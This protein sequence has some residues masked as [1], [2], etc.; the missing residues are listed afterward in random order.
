[1][2]EQ[3][4]TIYD[5]ARVLDVT[6]S[7]VSRA[8]RNHPRISARTKA[9]VQA[10]AEQLNY[11]QNHI[12]AALRSG[13]TFTLG[14]VVP[15]TNRN[16]FSSVIN[17]IEQLAFNSGYSV[18]ITQSNDS[19]E[20]EQ[21]NIEAL[22][23]AQVDGIIISVAREAGDPAVYQR[24]VAQGVPLVFFD[25]VVEVA[26]AS[27]VLIDDYQGAY[28]ATKHLI[29]QG[30]QRIAHL[31]GASHLN[32]YK[33]RLRG[34]RDALEDHQLPY[35]A[36]LIHTSKQKVADG[37]EGMR[38]LLTLSQPPDAVFAASDYA[39]IGAMQVCKERGLSIPQDVALVGFANEPLTAYLD[40]GLSSVDQMSEQMGRF[41]AKT[42]LEAIENTTDFTPH[43]T[44]LTPDLIVRASSQR[45]R[46]T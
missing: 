19:A 26:G 25:R 11:Q 42:F 34:Y 31:T 28:Q 14:V 4:A 24:V 7:T 36:A 12:A 37:S 22:L 45:K 18:I 15:Y 10:T 29:E 5:I 17:G 16:F 33:N 40:P 9:A 3:K 13:H 23:R 39:A 27:T 32:I 20:R 6:P 21:K 8:L 41:A 30:C 44:V 1:M 46:A 35:T 43:T 38:Q 2:A